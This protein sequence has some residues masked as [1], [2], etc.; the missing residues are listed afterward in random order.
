MADIKLGLTREAVQNAKETYDG[1]RTSFPATSAGYTKYTAVVSD[2][3]IKQG[4]GAQE[5]KAWLWLQVSNG[6][7]QDSILVNLDPSD[8]APTTAPDK[9]AQAVD[10]N[11][12]TLLRVV[13]V[14]GIA[15]AAS[16]G[17]DTAK[18]E[19]A[20]GTVITF[21]IKRG[22]LNAN[23]GYYKYYT[24]FYGKADELVPVETPVSGVSAPSDADSDIP[25]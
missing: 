16:D 2:I 9:V 7:Y 17:I 12:Q 13:K 19:Q 6:A 10:R 23:T 4:S 3:Q 1:P 21:G 15:N 11:L 25:F 14:L 24:S 20:K 22:D 5:G 8:I 18:F